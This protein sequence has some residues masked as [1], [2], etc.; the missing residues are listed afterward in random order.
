[1]ILKQIILLKVYTF[2]H[3]KGYA[4]HKTKI[5]KFQKVIIFLIRTVL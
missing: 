4:I 5:S 2:Y 1:M 3:K